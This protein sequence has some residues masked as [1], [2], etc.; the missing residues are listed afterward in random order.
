MSILVGP[1]MAK[2]YLINLRNDVDDHALEL[3]KMSRRLEE[4][5]ED[6]RF[7]IRFVEEARQYAENEGTQSP[8]ANS[9]PDHSAAR[10]NCLRFAKKYGLTL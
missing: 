10:E 6:L 4:M 1:F 3:N 7:V 2:D 9:L 5:E 8:W